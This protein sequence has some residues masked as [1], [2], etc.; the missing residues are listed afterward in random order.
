MCEWISAHID[1]RCGN[2]RAGGECRNLPAGNGNPHSSCDKP[3]MFEC[4]P[5][6]NNA[7]ASRFSAADADAGST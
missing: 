3:T 5:M 7:A 1:G 2:S 4:G 6:S